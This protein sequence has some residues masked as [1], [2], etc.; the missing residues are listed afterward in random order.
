MPPVVKKISEDLR[1]T[2]KN[3]IE[4]SQPDDWIP[5]PPTPIAYVTVMHCKN[6]QIQQELI[7]R[8]EHLKTDITSSPPLHSKVTKD[9]KDI[10]QVDPGDQTIGATEN[11]P[12][13]LILIEGDPGIGK[14]VLAKQI[15]CLWADH[16]LL[17]DCKLVFLVYLRNPRVHEMKS[18]EEL[19]CLF[20]AS[21]VSEYLEQCGGQNVAF[22]FDGFDEF[23]I[24]Q[25]DSIVKDI[26][27]VNKY[28][29]I[30]PRSTV[31]I[32][33]RPTAT[34]HLHELVNRRIVILGLAPGERNKLISL[35]DLQLPNK[36]QF[37]Q[38]YFMEHPII[39]SLCYIPLNL[40]ILLYLFK[41]N[42]FPV[43]L[44]E[45]NEAFVIHIVYRY[46][47]RNPSS[48]VT[49]DPI[50]AKHIQD[51]PKCIVNILNL[52]SELAFDGLQ[53]NQLVFKSED[54]SSEISNSGNGLSLLKAVEH[55][56]T[57]GVGDAIISYNFH[58]VT[59]QEYLAAY[60]VS[61]LPEEQQ[62][63]LLQTTFWTS[64]FNFMWMMYAGIVG[65]KTGAFASFV[66]NDKELDTIQQDKLKC[67]HFI[68]CYM[69]ANR[70]TEIPQTVSSVFA[71]G[72]I[73]LSGITLLSH[74]FAS[75]ILF[76]S[77]YVKHCESLEF[78]LK[79]LEL[80]NC[81][82]QK[83]EMDKLLEHTDVHRDRMST[84]K[85]V[86]LSENAF[87]PWDVYC[88][89]IK[90][91][92]G[93]SLILCGDEGIK[94]RIEQITN[95]INKNKTLQSLTLCS[96]GR[97]G[98][99]SIKEIMNTTK[100]KTLKLSWKRL[101]FSENTLQYTEFSSYTKGTLLTE[102]STDTNRAVNVNVNI[103]YDD[104]SH[105]R[106]LPSS[107]DIASN[108]NYESKSIINL[109]GKWINDDAVHVLAFGLCSN[110]TI[111]VLK[112]SSNLITDEG[113]IAIIDCLKQNKTLRKIDLSQNQIRNYKMDM[114]VEERIMTSFLEYVDLSENM[115]SPWTVYCAII[116]CCCVNSLTLCGDEGMEKC[117]QNIKSSLQR[118]TK[119]QSLT[120]LKIGKIGFNQLGKF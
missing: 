1:I 87:S 42:Y 53:K 64:H 62:R 11:K 16:K 73:R 32:T 77:S 79:S 108:Q 94:E 3:D 14:T 10:F 33:S 93:D 36:E 6:G 80:N 12:P 21:K 60:Y 44:T 92:S 22:I 70:G 115:S 47:K 119:L 68:Q 114:I 56:P 67:L 5:Y 50:H 37:I 101:D 105:N 90:H 88:A 7:N 106:L 19:L 96:I 110:T 23:S 49:K 59:M 95:V 24:L 104:D 91:C 89:I 103:I 74:H 66:R 54:I 83:N 69:E 82:L 120:L 29:R 2:Y 17:T 111:K 31:V 26:I 8:R 65:E 4:K 25:E 43:K 38:E 27:G 15:A 20:N 78:Q 41:Q 113:A 28:V 86:D 99:E 112:L 61:N 51:F 18:A 107:F 116:R 76:M 63:K 30:F 109:S 57:E 75:L 9:L 58:H 118:N 97:I 84:L 72:N 40:A 117:I 100:L 81:N 35:S 46:I 52:L 55:Y 48:N 13:K 98:I 85:Y 45:I 39:S 71:G 102:I 34:L